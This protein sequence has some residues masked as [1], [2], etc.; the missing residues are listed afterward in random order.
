MNKV[1]I[2]CNNDQRYI[3]GYINIDMSCLSKR[4]TD[5]LNLAPIDIDKYFE[6]GEIDELLVDDCLDFLSWEQKQA[7]IAML[8]N[9]IC[10]GGKIHISFID[11]EELVRKYSNNK[12]QFKELNDTLFSRNGL[13]KVSISTSK[14]IVELLSKNRFLISK[15]SFSEEVGLIEGVAR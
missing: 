4:L 5:V 11:F 3:N 7:F 12:M 13:N 15:I 2:F 8:R 9:K 1:N 6:N 14:S 10:R